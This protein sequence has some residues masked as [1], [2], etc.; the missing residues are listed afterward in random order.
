[1]IGFFISFFLLVCTILPWLHI[2]GYRSTFL[3]IAF[4]PALFFYLTALSTLLSFPQQLTGA[5]FL[6]LQCFI[7]SCTYI[8]FPK[9]RISTKQIKQA[10]LNIAAHVKKQK[11][12]GYIIILLIFIGFFLLLSFLLRATTPTLSFD[13]VVYRASTP[14]YWIE[15]KSIFRFPSAREH[16]NIFLYGTGVLCMWPNLFQAGERITN[17]LYWTAFPIITILLYV[18]G[19]LFTKN[20]IHRLLTGMLFVTAPII[21]RHASMILIQEMWLG[22]IL[23]SCVYTV[24][25]A[26]HAE[27]KTTR[28][29]WWYLGFSFG[30]LPIIKPTGWFYTLLLLLLLR[31]K[32][33]K[34][35][36]IVLAGFLM[37]FVLSGYLLLLHQN[38]QL[39]GS[40]GGSKP[41]TA[42]HTAS[43]SFKQLYIH[44]LRLPFLFLRLPC[45]TNTCFPFIDTTMQKIISFVGADTPLDKEDT[46]NWIGTFQYGVTDPDKNF[47][48][49]GIIW[50]FLIFLSLA[51]LYSL[52]IKKK[53]LS[54]NQLL[55]LG[56]TSITLIQMY[57]IR[58]EDQSGV[59]YKHLI[60][61]FAVML[62][63][64][65]RLFTYID[66]R[67]YR[68][69]S[70]IFSIGILLLSV[71]LFTT[72][73]RSIYIWTHTP[74]IEMI[75][76]MRLQENPYKN[77]LPTIPSHSNI[78]VIEPFNAPDYQLFASNT[79]Q[80]NNVY[81]FTIPFDKTDEHTI[82]AMHQYIVKHNIQYL[83]V[84]EH[85]ELI[86]KVLQ[87]PTTYQLFATIDFESVPMYII[88]IVNP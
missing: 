77:L 86:Q 23:L 64:C 76:A 44:T 26:F 73:M 52:I 19:S 70:T 60:G 53:P 72:T 40:P 21:F 16:K 54:T 51:D 43:T 11:R 42:I 2:I 14:L 88:K 78:L 18:I 83:F 5:N 62:L 37:S 75:H 80:W 17:I 1:M 68:Y 46:E 8:F 13:D 31:K 34:R 36:P 45:Y 9:H 38:Y 4:F 58:W 67:V 56:L 39:Y 66:T 35:I 85:S 81:L 59:P 20:K 61:V 30:I 49:G 15:Q 82:Q 33:I 22:V 69:S 57:L 10:V 71:P 25:H 63:F 3:F 41:F 6:I 87:M 28:Q 27:Q 29:F 32:F 24:I 74:T 12:S 79:N 84:Q 65:Y 50:F 7:F 47:G 48:F 55:L